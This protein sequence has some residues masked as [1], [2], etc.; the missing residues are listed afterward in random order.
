MM[1]T[2]A[3]TQR[4]ISIA[5]V[6]FF[7]SQPITNV[8]LL[9]GINQDRELSIGQN[10]A[11]TIVTRRRMENYFFFAVFFLVIFLVPHFLPHAIA[12]HLLP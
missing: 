3:T 7:L 8:K 10:K 11:G 1:E 6:H 2:R 5:I 12:R 4:S 9:V